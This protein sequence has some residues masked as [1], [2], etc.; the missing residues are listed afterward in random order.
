MQ[1]KD[2]GK[3][4]GNLSVRVY[5]VKPDGSRELLWRVAKKNQITDRGRLNVLQ[6]LAQD[7]AGLPV[8]VDP[9]KGQIWSLGVGDSTIPPS[10]VQT[11]LISPVWNGA[12][13]IPTE[14]AY[15]PALYELQISKEVAAGTATGSTFAE[16]GLFTRGDEDSPIIAPDWESI[17]NRVMY[18]RQI[19]SPFVKGLTMSVVFDWTLGMTIA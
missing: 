13:T 16:A 3:L 1:V 11:G 14:R 9:L 17:V 6:L 15:V 8:Q 2:S 10:S 7:A 4:Y 18:A 5:D 19:F 12:L